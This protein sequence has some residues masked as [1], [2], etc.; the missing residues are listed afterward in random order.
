MSRW[1]NCRSMKLDST[2]LKRRMILRR[3]SPKVIQVEEVV[4]MEDV[5]EET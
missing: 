3:F 5:L 1:D 2:D 4:T